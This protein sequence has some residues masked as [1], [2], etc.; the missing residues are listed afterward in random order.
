MSTPRVPG[1]QPQSGAQ[2][3]LSALAS[4]GVDH[5]FMVPGGHNDPLMTPMAT[6][7]NMTTIVAAFEGGAAFMADGYS[8]ATGKVGAAF[9][10]GGPGALN[11]ATALASSAADRVP[12]L[13]VSGEVPVDWEGRGG[14]QD[15]SSTALDDTAVMRS[16]CGHSS[17][18]ESAG[19]LPLHLRGAL[20]HAIT[21][22]RPA[23][24]SIPV[25][26]QNS[27]IT[28]PWV[29]LPSDLH[30]PLFLDGNATDQVLDTLSGAGRTIAILAGPGL[31][32][33][34]EDELAALADKW[35]IPVA[36]TLG[37][38]GILP[39]D[40]PLSVGVFGYGG[41]RW[42]TE[43]I[44]G[45][46]LEIL[47]VVGSALSQRDTMTWDR[48]M[49]PSHALIHCDEDPALLTRTWPQSQV[50]I[51]APSPFLR[52]LADADGEP[53]RGL[54]AGVGKRADLLARV[55]ALGPRSYDVDTRT[56]NNVPLHPAR[57]IAEARKAF[58][59]DTV[60]VVDAG[61][62]RAFA[63]QHWQAFGPRSY[64]CATNMGPMGAAVPM[65]VGSAAARPHQ[66]HLCITSDGCML[67]HGMEL[68]TAAQHNLPMTLL[69]LNNHSYG[70]IWFRADSMGPR[71]SALTDIVGIDW[72]EFGRAM[73]AE[74]VRVERPDQLAAAFEMAQAC[75][76]PCVIDARTDKTAV[77]PTGEWAAALADWEDND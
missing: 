4:E 33:N 23:H 5:V 35:H 46:D 16:V 40:H 51:G 70:N 38:K 41:S 63:A 39:E 52:A 66:H 15:A 44:M 31:R 50:V 17:R 59:R 22:R 29:P 65:T 64:L 24:L 48:K 45:S 58:P 26:I 27:P 30:C 14:F 61:A 25:D 10:I 11:M 21:K 74:S 8:R 55:Q 12:V 57:V 2:F 76:G 67:M 1:N 77:K 69:V 56:S 37:A 75:D 36:T 43:L 49:L 7:A 19:T 28:T 9:G 42:A 13:A 54:A 62:H 72:A 18:A 20:L 47:I 32:R 3:V 60:A 68:H 6:T 34:G 53:A 71:E 73:G